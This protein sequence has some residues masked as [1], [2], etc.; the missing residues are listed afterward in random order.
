MNAPIDHTTDDSSGMSE[1]EFEQSRQF[2]SPF[3]RVYVTKAT[4]GAEMVY[5]GD[6]AGTTMYDPA[7]DMEFQIEDYVCPPQSMDASDLRDWITSA[8]RELQQRVTATL[9]DAF[10]DTVGIT[11]WY[12]PIELTETR[13]QLGTR[14]DRTDGGD[15][16]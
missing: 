4:N 9:P 16:A 15:S 10:G 8:P 5:F 11:E 14:D 2:Y 12:P 3:T 7:L 13:A 6:I 1:A